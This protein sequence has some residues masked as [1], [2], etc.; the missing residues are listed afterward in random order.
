MARALALLL[1]GAALLTG[2]CAAQD[3]VIDD[4]P[5]R[6][7]IA[8]W[9][10][11]FNAADTIADQRTVLDTTVRADQRDEQADCPAATALL[12]LDPAWSGLREDPAGTADWVLPVFIEILRNGTRDG[13]DIATLHFWIVDGTARIEALCV[14]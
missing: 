8:T 12:R 7:A 9:I 2:A 14:I 5:Q 10:D 13:T 1:A 6:A 11:D 3:H 4:D